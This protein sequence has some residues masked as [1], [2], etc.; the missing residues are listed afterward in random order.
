MQP[1]Y[2]I[3]DYETRSEADLKRVGAY[4]YARHPSTRILCAAFRF[5]TRTTLRQAPVHVFS[6]G[7]NSIRGQIPALE[8]LVSQLY[9]PETF[10]VAHNAFFEQVITR[11]VLTQYVRDLR[12]KTLP[13]ERWICTAS[14]AAALALP[15]KLADAGRALH[16]PVQK[17]QDGHRLMLKMS[18]PRK[19]TRD[20]PAKWHNRVSDLKRLIEYCVR[21]VETETELFLNT[22]ELTPP[23]RK[24]WCL[25]Q[26]MNWRG[27]QV[28]RTLVGKIEK[29]IVQESERFTAETQRITGGEIQSINQRNAVLEWIRKRGLGLA[30]LRA[31]TVQDTLNGDLKPGKAR[32]LLELR[33]WASKTSTAK[34]AAFMARSGTDSRVRDPHVRDSRVRDSRIRDFQVFHGASTGRFSGAG[35]QVQN[36]PRGTLANAPDVADF[37]SSTEPDLDLLRTVYGNPL[38]LFSSLLRACIQAS[39][40]K[41]LFGGDFAGIEV[42]VLF[43]LARH[44]TGLDAVRTD[45]DLYRELATVI[46]GKPIAEVTK[47]EREVAKR[48]VLGCGFGMGHVKFE[49]TCKNFGQEVSPTLAQ[50]AVA[51]YRTAHGPV[52][53]LWYNLERAAIYAVEHPGK[54][55]QINR[56]TWWV[57]KDFLFC[58]LP[59]G[60]KIAYAGPEIHSKKTP[61]GESR[62]SL[63]HWD[64]LPGSRQ[65][66]L[67]ATYGGKLAE[68]VTQATARDFMTD[69]MVRVEDAG[70]DLLLTVHDELLAEREG[71]SEAE[72]NQLMSAVPVWGDGM[73]IRVETWSGLRYQK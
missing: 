21:D 3:L 31:K 39:P 33:S 52:P 6:P 22:P 58:E 25:D 24:L 68:N 19:P 12:V 8:K 49:A 43:W 17:D 29:M 53:R 18:K 59:S 72:F 13:P 48:A 28:D 32:D 69:A 38:D 44:E 35:I 40:G 14:Q 62:P 55:I 51:A 60:R 64:V 27:F 57:E 26:K 34:Y 2:C 56:T 70:Y 9:S 4:E 71:G 63:H 20:N 30:D 50:A 41:T 61:W 16:L 10:L 42:R 7:M 47:P 73:P 54:R 23:E 66:A 5:G 67:N 11:F 37:I 45:R 15:R 1:T 65:W 36:F 46:Y